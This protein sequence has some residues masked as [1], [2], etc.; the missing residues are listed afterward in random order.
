MKRNSVKTHLLCPADEDTKF[1]FVETTPSIVVR[2]CYSEDCEIVLI[3]DSHRKI[4]SEI[5]RI[6]DHTGED[7]V[8]CSECSMDETVQKWG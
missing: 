1:V 7:R 2:K 5:F 4:D 8:Y 6:Q 3:W